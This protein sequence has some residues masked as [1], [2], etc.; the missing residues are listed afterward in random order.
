MQNSETVRWR[1][2][3]PLLLVITFST[4]MH[5]CGADD[6]SSSGGAT[7][8]DDVADS[9]DDT[10]LNGVAEEAPEEDS[11]AGESSDQ[12]DGG[13]GNP[14]F[15]TTLPD[16]NNNLTPESPVG[17]WM[18]VAEEFSEIP[19]AED[20]MNPFLFE[21]TNRE[22]V[23]VTE[24]AEGIY[25]LTRCDGSWRDEYAL[26]ATET[27]YDATYSETS[28]A[29]EGGV[30]YTTTTQFSVVYGENNQTLA[31]SGSKTTQPAGED[32]TLSV[33]GVKVSDAPDF[34][35]AD[36]FTA[37]AQ[38]VYVELGNADAEP[39][40]A[41]RTYSDLPV[42][43]VGSSVGQKTTEST[44]DEWQLDQRYF[45]VI[46]NTPRSGPSDQIQY[47]EL[48]QNTEGELTRSLGAV[49]D[50]SGTE[51]E[52]G[53]VTMY[54]HAC[55][56]GSD[57]ETECE[58]GAEWTETSSASAEGVSFDINFEVVD[59][60]YVVNPLALTPFTAFLRPHDGD[61]MR[62]QLAVTLITDGL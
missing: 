18:L 11:G 7:N 4:L 19:N 29:D 12:G 62:T 2:L 23:S 9:S 60:A 38:L 22:F 17:I 55:S 41:P 59:N 26:T 43:C 3:F 48:N 14:V 53:A 45:T 35:A 56:V 6:G 30:E 10:S 50:V 34:Y 54:V 20:S 28:G 1:A 32:L 15:S 8:S 21:K 25:V 44:T 47:Y 42:H 40:G 58:A 57:E 13:T 27:G 24:N 31:V 39:E 49:I 33:E 46:L 36:E 16:V 5:G 51:S 52:P 61:F 37:S